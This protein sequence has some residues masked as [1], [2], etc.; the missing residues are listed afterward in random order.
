MHEDN[1]KENIDPQSTYELCLD[2]YQHIVFDD[3]VPKTALYFEIHKKFQEEGDIFLNAAPL[4]AYFMQSLELDIFLSIAKLLDDNRSDR[5]ILKFISYCE[6]NR[7]KIKWKDGEIPQKIIN[8]HRGEIELRQDF[9]DKI[10][11]RRDKFLAHN[12]KEF[13]LDR[14][15]LDEEYPI[16]ASEVVDLIRCFQRILGD[17]S[18]G[19]NG[20]A[21]I[22]MDGFVTAAAYKLIDQMMQNSVTES[23]S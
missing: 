23:S 5:N 4:F 18:R 20:R 6:T 21:R 22:S 10:V 11:T 9:I 13:F 15:K 1:L 12:D 8:K 17:H 2:G 16:S 14:Q 19:F 7:K 3:L